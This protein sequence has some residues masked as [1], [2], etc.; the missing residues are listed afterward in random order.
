M[1]RSGYFKIKWLL[2]LL[3]KRLNEGT[4]IRD[5]NVHVAVF[6]LGYFI[7]VRNLYALLKAPLCGIANAQRYNVQDKVLY[8][9]L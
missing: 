2:I 6:F 3:G 5:S 7:D 1:K 9:V 8:C 4:N